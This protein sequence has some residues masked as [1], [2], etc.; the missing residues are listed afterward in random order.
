MPQHATPPAPSDS[1]LKVSTLMF[2]R[3]LLHVFDARARRWAGGLAICALASLPVAAST[4][5]ADRPLGGIAAIVNE[6]LISI[7][8]VTARLG[9][10]RL[11]NQAATS[12]RGQRRMAQRALTELI[13]EEI[14]LQEAKRLAMK[15]SSTDLTKA[16]QTIAQN[17]QLSV[18]DLRRKMADQNVDPATLT[19]RLRAEILWSRAVARKYLRLVQITDT[20]IDEAVALDEAARNEPRDRLS[21]IVLRRDRAKSL[22]NLRRRAEELQRLLRDGASFADLARQY[23]EAPSAKAGGAVGWIPRGRLPALLETAVAD[24]KIGEVSASLETPL[25]I[26][27]LRL[28]DRQTDAAVNP[29]NDRVTL[30]QVFVPVSA[31]TETAQATA[32]ATAQ[33]VTAVV[34]SCAD[35]RRLAKE[36]N[37]PAS[38]DL[39]TMAI[40]DLA[41]KLRQQVLPL[42]VNTPTAPITLPNGFMVLMVCAREA[43]APPKPDRESIRAR[44]R[45]ERLSAYARQ[46]LIDLRQVA[47]VDRRL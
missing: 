37:S 41:P 31:D 12:A 43:V 19:R 47:T 27:L 18:E 32:E 2:T 33:R 23:S 39:G 30:A 16:W 1:V 44:L 42:A 29:L 25:G 9:L 22:E 14:K 10:M 20:E 17:N 35:L 13:E 15:V 28:D 5:A 4:K 36:I 11:D 26:Q 24:L 7:R 45:E 6:Q 3:F 34:T 21:E 8:D 46:Y 40:G 38:P